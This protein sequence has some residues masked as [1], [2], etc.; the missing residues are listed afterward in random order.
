MKVKKLL[1]LV[2]SALMAVTMLT[3]CGG[4]SES[5]STI[6]ISGGNKLDMDR[7]NAYIAASGS[8]VIVKN[9]SVL[10]GALKATVAWAGP[11]YS[12]GSTTNI[13]R[14][15]RNDIRKYPITDTNTI[16]G[17]Y[18]YTDGAAKS[19]SENDLLNSGKSLD[20][21]AADFVLEAAANSDYTKH[22]N[23]GAQ[24]SWSV[25]AMRGTDERYDKNYWIIAYE[26]VIECYTK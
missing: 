21:M 16:T 9:S 25:S 20:E 3:A 11:A 17:W 12:L 18:S 8:S 6:G 10:N 4:G 24:M 26:V 1:A 7:V 23:R 14:K 2:L 19:I 5:G 13:S 22:A 15:L